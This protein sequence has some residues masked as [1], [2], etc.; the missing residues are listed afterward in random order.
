MG[1]IKRSGLKKVF[2]YVKPS[3]VACFYLSDLQRKQIVDWSLGIHKQ[4]FFSFLSFFHPGNAY[5]TNSFPVFIPRKWTANKSH[6]WL[7]SIETN[8]KFRPSPLFNSIPSISLHPNFLVWKLCWCSIALESKTPYYHLNFIYDFAA[9]AYAHV[10]R[11]TSF[12]LQ[13]WANFCYIR[14]LHF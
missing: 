12:F 10:Y 4:I 9:H 6:E 1:E 3:F 8:E 7:Y 11:D 14:G 5:M 13:K 2:F